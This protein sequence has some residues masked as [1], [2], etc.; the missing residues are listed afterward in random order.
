MLM[1][2]YY[3]VFDMSKADEQAAASSSSDPIDIANELA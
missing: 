2:K 1:K 3:T